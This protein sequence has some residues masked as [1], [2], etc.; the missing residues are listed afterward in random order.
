MI[1]SYP[2]I[3]LAPKQKEAMQVVGIDT[4]PENIKG[5]LT[6]ATESLLRGFTESKV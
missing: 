4:T 5:E 1:G 6:H 3:D 2:M